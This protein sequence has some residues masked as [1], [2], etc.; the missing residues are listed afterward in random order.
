MKH[1]FRVTLHCQ[2]VALCAFV[3]EENVIENTHPIPSRPKLLIFQELDVLITEHP[4]N[5]LLLL[6][7][8]KSR[9]QLDFICL[10]FQTHRAPASWSPAVHHRQPFVGSAVT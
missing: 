10:S 4:N 2:V 5:K 7:T 6:R 1:N 3:F 8:F 9:T